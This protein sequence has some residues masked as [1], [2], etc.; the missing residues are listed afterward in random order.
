[1]LLCILYVIDIVKFQIFPCVSIHWKRVCSMQILTAQTTWFL[2]SRPKY[3]SRSRTCAIDTLDT[4]AKIQRILDKKIKKWTFKD[5]YGLKNISNNTEMKMVQC[6]IHK[7]YNITSTT[8][9]KMVITPK[10]LHV[11][12]N[13]KY[14]DHHDHGNIYML[15]DINEKKPT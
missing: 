14:Y 15:T 11:N 12:M 9:R 5:N 1:M 3:G 13:F 8:A 10:S 6:R 4:S 7:S 2:I